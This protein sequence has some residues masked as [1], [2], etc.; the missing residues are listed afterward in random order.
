MNGNNYQ[1]ADFNV[2]F[3]KAVTG[4]MF[5]LSRVTYSNFYLIKMADWRYHFFTSWAT[6]STPY[7]P[8]TSILTNPFPVQFVVP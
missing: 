4:C 7:L 1:A 5:L 3:F 2:F 6:S 8:V